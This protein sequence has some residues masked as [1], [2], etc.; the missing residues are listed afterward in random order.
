MKFET[1]EYELLEIN[2]ELFYDFG[3]IGNPRIIADLTILTDFT[4]K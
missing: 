4:M 1:Y 3:N 2:F